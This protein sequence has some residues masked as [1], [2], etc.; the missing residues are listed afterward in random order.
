MPTPQDLMTES[1]N[2]QSTKD[3]DKI[4]FERITSEYQDFRIL[5][6]MFRAQNSKLLS[7]YKKHDP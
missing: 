4:I 7:V 3:G 1:H 6:Q 2:S 5:K